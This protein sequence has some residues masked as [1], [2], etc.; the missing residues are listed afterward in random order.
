MKK[1]CNAYLWWDE[2]G[3]TS[4]CQSNADRGTTY[5]EC[6]KMEQNHCR[7]AFLEFDGVMW[8]LVGEVRFIKY[9]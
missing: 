9:I 7:Q 6:G 8:Y 1:G 2:K 4:I 5:E 3:K